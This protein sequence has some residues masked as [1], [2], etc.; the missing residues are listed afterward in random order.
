M[1][2]ID[3]MQY[4]LD[5]M[6]CPWLVDEVEDGNGEPM[7]PEDWSWFNSEEVNI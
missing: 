5:T 6:D 7:E 2:S 3:N 4:V 1:G